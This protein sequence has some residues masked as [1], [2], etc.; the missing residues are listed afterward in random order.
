[1][2]DSG[3][4]VNLATGQRCA[5]VIDSPADAGDVDVVVVGTGAGALTAAVRAHDHG[6]K[7]L[8]VEK[9]ELFGGTSAV[10]GGGI[11][12]PNNDHIER[13]GGSDSEAEALAYLQAATR[14]E[15]APERLAAYVH[16]APRMLR[17]VEQHTPVRYR[18]VPFY[19]DYYQ[20]LP[21]AKTGYRTLD[22]EPFDARCLGDELLRMR[23]TSPTMLIFGRMGMTTFEAVTLLARLPGW[24]K[25]A[26]RIFS[27]YWLDAVWRLRSRRDRR[28]TM[29]S[30]LVGALRRAAM[31][32]G[33]ALWM[34]AS[35]QSLVFD[36][37]RVTG[38]KLLRDGKPVT[39]LARHGVVLAAGGFESNQRMRE[40]YLPQ[41]TNAKWTAAPPCNTGDA[42][43]AGEGIGAA[44]DGM[45][46]AWWTPTVHVPGE[47]KQRGLFS[48]RALPGC[49]VVNRKGD[50]FANEAMDYLDFVAA[51][52]EDHEKTGANLPAFMVFD[53]NFRHKYNAGPLVSGSVIP[54]RRL[55]PDWLGKAYFRAD[56]LT[57]L[58]HRIG[59]DAQG[60]QRTVERMNGYAGSG[61]DEQFGK[62]DNAYDR[63][64][65]DPTVQPNPCLGPILKA[66]FYALKLD[67]GEIGTKGGL[68]TDPHARVVDADQRP[69][70]GLYATG[71]TSASITGPSYPGA[72]ATLGPA[73][74]FGYIAANHIAAQA[75]V[76]ADRANRSAHA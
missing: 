22:P 47:E 55:P 27:R 20:S 28:L 13:D 76:G 54:D 72:G 36:G 51:M 45:Q 60:L 11:W 38:V 74:T 53:A 18:A 62:G 5:T 37:R 32:R 46:H 6:L 16:E 65:G 75:Q 50:R 7:V 34:K 69:I 57:E 59:V 15:V 44:L 71:N 14:G 2:Q 42:I 66:P 39:V 24:K 58:A 70:P 73:M 52:Y 61:V 19:A 8:V 25:L 9:A 1:M 63:I 43:R 21:G 33:I 49:V 4:A 30:A 23:E 12:I 31:D 3:A 35:L 64:Y 17:W 41:P 29:G 67:A 68:L 26:L 40:Q 48:E 10:S 56:T